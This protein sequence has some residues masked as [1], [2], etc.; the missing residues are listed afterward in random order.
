MALATPA[1]ADGGSGGGALTST[2]GGTDNTTGTGGVGCNGASGDYIATGGAGGAAG[3]GVTAGSDGTGGAG[4]SGSNLTIT[5]SGMITG[6]LGGNG[7]TRADAATAQ[8]GAD[9]DLAPDLRL[10]LGYDGL[11]SD[12]S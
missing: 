7:T 5:N 1:S 2:C 10:H 8:V 6:G 9:L 3:T 12:T 11:L 4:I